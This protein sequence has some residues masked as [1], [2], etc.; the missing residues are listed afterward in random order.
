MIT[1][2]QN[3]IDTMDEFIG[4]ED[5]TIEDVAILLENALPLENYDEKVDDAMYLMQDYVYGYEHMP[6]NENKHFDLEW[7]NDLEGTINDLDDAL[8]KIDF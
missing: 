4:V 2:I 8:N 6:K 1:K 7:G 5:P 3:A